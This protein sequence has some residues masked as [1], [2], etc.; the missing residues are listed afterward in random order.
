MTG[1]Q[2]QPAFWRFT[3]KSAKEAVHLYFEPVRRLT[4]WLSDCLQDWR[5]FA[6][7]PELIA[8]V[9]VMFLAVGIGLGTALGN[10]KAVGLGLLVLSLFALVWVNIRVLELRERVH[11]LELLRALELEVLALAPEMDPQQVGALRKALDELPALQL[12]LDPEE[13]LAVLRELERDPTLER[14][15]TRAGRA[16][17]GGAAARGGAE[18]HRE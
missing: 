5:D 18:A 8:A 12:D 3:L 6:L 4:L 10:W 1:T 13:A 17:A 11:K 7:E 15:R 9:G 16:D 14:L 2:P